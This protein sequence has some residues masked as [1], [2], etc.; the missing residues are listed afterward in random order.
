LVTARPK[1]MDSQILLKRLEIINNLL[2]LEDYPTLTQQ[3][4]HL[5]AASAYKNIPDVL[6][7]IHRQAWEQAHQILRDLIA[8]G[9]ALTLYESPEIAELRLALRTL[10][11]QVIALSTEQIETEQLIEQF[12]KRQNN[13]IGDILGQYLQLREQ[14]YAR[15]AQS[16]ST[17]DRQAYQEAK[18]ENESYQQGYDP[19]EDLSP[20]DA[21]TPEQQ[22]E[23]KTLHRQA[24][25]LCHP[26]RVSEADKARAQA[27]FNQVQQAYK[28]AD[29]ETMRR[30]QKN[31]KDGK[32][33]EEP[34]EMPSEIDQ[35]RRQVARLRLEVE[36]YLTA[37][38]ALRQT[39][40]F[41]TLSALTDWDN[42]FAEARKQLESE[43]EKLQAELEQ[44][45]A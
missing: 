39:E 28:N 37:I 45:E 1:P 24:R 31:L 14:V 33:F 38:S 25:M 26:D 6:D 35:L 15:R 13:L 32:P 18:V 21:L 17:E 34:A 44:V 41:K 2:L 36:R 3:L 11:A 23:L 9:K 42:H 43:C 10:E 12:S 8:N 7:A 20:V 27:V 22:D 4:P 29:L 19:N 16:G 30:L 5:E 40:T